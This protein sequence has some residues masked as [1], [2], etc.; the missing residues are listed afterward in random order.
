MALGSG[1]KT[2]LGMLEFLCDTQTRLFV[3]GGEPQH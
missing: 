1:H 2:A 3:V